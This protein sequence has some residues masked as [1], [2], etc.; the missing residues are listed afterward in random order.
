MR[1]LKGGGVSDAPEPPEIPRN[2]LAHCA[3]V[4]FWGRVSFLN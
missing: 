3:L 1:P 4:S 2:A